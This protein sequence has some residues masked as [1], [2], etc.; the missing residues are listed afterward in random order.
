MDK[1][2]KEEVTED[3]F[4]VEENNKNVKVWPMAAFFI[5]TFIFVVLGYVNWNIFTYNNRAKAT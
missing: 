1:K 3:L 4:L 5:I 2:N